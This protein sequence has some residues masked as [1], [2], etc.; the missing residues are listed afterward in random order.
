MK[1]YLFAFVCL[2]ISHLTVAQKLTYQSAFSGFYS[3]AGDIHRTSLYLKQGVFKDLKADSSRVIKI[4]IVN[5]NQWERNTLGN[6]RGISLENGLGIGL[7]REKQ[8][9][10]MLRQSYGTALLFFKY[11]DNNMPREP[12]FYKGTLLFPGIEYS[13]SLLFPI[14]SSF[15]GPFLQLTCQY[16]NRAYQNYFYPSWGVD[17]SDNYFNIQFKLGLTFRL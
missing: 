4:G 1:K 12:K 10:H 16:G 7:I 14:K 11:Y 5:A 8:I 6:K 17:D 3:Q 9:N 15:I 13:E 2:L